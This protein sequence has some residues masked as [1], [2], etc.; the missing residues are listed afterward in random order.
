MTWKFTETRFGIYKKYWRKNQFQGTDTLSTR[1]G[2][3][4]PPP[5]RAPQSRGSPDADSFGN[6]FINSK[7]LLH[8][9]SGHSE[10]LYFCTKITPWQFCWKQH[11][12]G[13]VPF[14]SCKLEYKT[15]SKV[16]IKVDTMETYQH[17]L[18]LL[19]IVILIDMQVVIPITRTWSISYITYHSSHSSWPYHIT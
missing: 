13:L 3:M 5:G 4:P 7:K 14:K 18:W 8:L 19:P 12:S 9:F 11:Q 1:V 17:L 16:F 10:N 2:G 6:I 15:R